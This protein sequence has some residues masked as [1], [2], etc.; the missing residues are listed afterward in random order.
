MLE[1]SEHV[2]WAEV[3]ENASVKWSNNYTINAKIWS[4]KYIETVFHN[5][6]SGLCTNVSTILEVT[7]VHV[8]LTSMQDWV[9]LTESVI[10]NLFLGV[11]NNQIIEL[12]IFIDSWLAEYV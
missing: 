10:R 5:S 6:E 2:V 11:F 12:T 1:F 7:F 9:I 8:D 4:E 3:S